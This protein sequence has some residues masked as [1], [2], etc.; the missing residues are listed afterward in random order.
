MKSIIAQ[1]QKT[2]DD[3]SVYGYFTTMMIESL[4]LFFFTFFVRA[5]RIIMP[6]FMLIALLI[7]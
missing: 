2:L 6:V 7:A 4:M 3:A 1:K 5:I